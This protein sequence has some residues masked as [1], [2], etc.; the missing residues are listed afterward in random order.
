MKKILVNKQKFIL[1]LFAI[2]ILII[3]KVLLFVYLDDKYLY[4]SY[5]LLSFMNGNYT[6]NISVN[7]A[8]HFF[9][10]FNIF[11]FHTIL[12]WNIFLAIIG[13]IIVLLIILL[14]KEKYSF[15]EYIFILISLFLLDLYV[16][17]LSKE[18]IQFLIFLI[19]YLII[20]NLK[21]PLNIKVIIVTIILFLEAVYFRVY[22]G[23]I[24]MLFIFIYAFDYLFF[25][26]K[27]KSYLIFIVLITLIL[28]VYFIKLIS[29]DNLKAIINARQL[30]NID[31]QNSKDAIT[32]INDLFF[33]K[34]LYFSFVINYFLNFLRMNIPLEL[35][36]KG[37]K[38]I[39]YIILQIFI[40]FNIFKFSKKI[41]KNNILVYLLIIC[42]LVVSVL[43]EPDFGS[44]LRHQSAFL[45]FYFEMIISNQDNYM[46]LI[47]I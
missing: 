11:S 20:I 13:N 21:I 14:K 26:D 1:I 23:L 7:F 31:R 28:G 9:D 37:I 22:Y 18:F 10:F 45:L 19:M 4:D 24:G 42:F 8:A 27:K 5:Y 12:E 6:S 40:T 38:Y 33:H 30:I 46:K 25:K 3:A 39:P 29:Y 41:D 44:F 34:N 35:I 17:T 43:F 36:F 16:F 2:I 47:D 15:I 32:I